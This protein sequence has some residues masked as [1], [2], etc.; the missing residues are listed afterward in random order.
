V[1]ERA[2]YAALEPSFANRRRQIRKILQQDHGVQCPVQ[3][4]DHHLCHVAAAYYTSGFAD[5]LVC[6]VDGGGDGKSSSIYA[7]RNGRLERVHETRA[8]DSLGNYYAYLTHM[9]GFR[10]M[11]HEGKVTGL[12]AHGVARYVA[13]LRDFID[14]VGGTLVNRGGAVFGEAIRRL[15]KRL[16]TGWTREDLAASIQAHFEDVTRRYVSHWARQTGLRDVARAGGVLANVRVN[17]EIWGLPETSRLFVHPGMTDAG[18]AVG[19]ALAACIPGTLDRPMAASTAPLKDV[20]LGPT[21]IE[22]E[23]DDA[24]RRHDLQPEPVTGALPQVIADLLAAGY[25]V[26]RAAG[27]MEYGPRALGNRSILYQPSD[28]AVNDWLNKNL[29]RT[30]FMPFAPAILH[31]EREWCF[32]DMTG[33]EHTAEFMTMTFHCTP[34]MRRA[35]AGVV[36]LDGTARPQL[37]RA[38]RNAEFHAILSA[39]RDRTGLPGIINTS[40]NMHEEPIVCSAEDAVRAFLD[41]HLDYLAL[42]ERLIRH[43]RGPQR[44]LQPALGRPA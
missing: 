44:E 25:V 26:A 41:G 22:P 31:V 30:E 39:F 17:E 3:F 32:G 35:M 43:P 29:R 40:F 5:A 19:A 20:Y 16:P 11:R 21:I 12:A 7:A 10:A 34:A 2:Y 1:L 27:R 13:L 8:F 36:H 33:A 18:L 38:D 24:L 28:R 23:I 6:S 4:V 37:V 14:E 9:M 15:T 42:G